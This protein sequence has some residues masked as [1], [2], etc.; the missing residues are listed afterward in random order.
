MQF[1]TALNLIW[2]VLGVFALAGTLRARRHGSASVAHAPVWLHVC[3]VALIL[4]ALFPYISATDDV[5]RIQHMDVEQSNAHH[6]QSSKKSPSDALIR[7]YETMDTPIVGAVRQISFV[8]FFVSLVLTPILIVTTRSTPLR[9][10][11]SPPVS[12]SQIATAN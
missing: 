8:V 1:D 11:R 5:L 4:A 10:G 3:G 6:S 7:L 9:S 12:F 2:L